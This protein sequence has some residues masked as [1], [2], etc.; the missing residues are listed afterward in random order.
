VNNVAPKGVIL[1]IS[2]HRL[3]TRQNIPH[4]KHTQKEDG[5]WLSYA[6]I[7]LKIMDM[8]NV[9]KAVDQLQQAVPADQ[10]R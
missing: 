10:S 4:P 5:A 9:V 6:I 3:W 1:C 7:V 8:V 2:K